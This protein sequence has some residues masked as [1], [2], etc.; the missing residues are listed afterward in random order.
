MERAATPLFGVVT[1]GVHATMYTQDY[2]LW[3]AKRALT[4]QT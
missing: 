3:V 2:R 1:Y 4:K